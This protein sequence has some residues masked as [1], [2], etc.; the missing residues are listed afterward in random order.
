M[1]GKAYGADLGRVTMSFT[2]FTTFIEHRYVYVRGILYRDRETHIYV[3]VLGETGKTGKPGAKA[4][5]ISPLAFT[6]HW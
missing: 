5:E 2:T 3:Y 1:V 6:S 4:F